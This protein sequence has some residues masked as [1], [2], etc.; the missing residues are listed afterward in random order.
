LTPVGYP[1]RGFGALGPSAR[2]SA[3]ICSR[4]SRGILWLRLALSAAR[5]KGA[6]RSSVSRLR[7]VCLF[8]ARSVGLVRFFPTQGTLGH[9]AVHG[10]P[11]P[12]EALQF[13]ATEQPIHPQLLDDLGLHAFLKPPGAPR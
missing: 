9:R 13:V 2:R 8:L 4:V 12:V 3:S 1:D 7:L 10:N 11:S 6:P 5:A